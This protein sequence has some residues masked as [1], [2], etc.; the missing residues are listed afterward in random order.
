MNIPLFYPKVQYVD[1][2]EEEGWITLEEL[3]QNANVLCRASGPWTKRRIKMTAS[4]N[5]DLFIKAHGSRSDVWVQHPP[6]NGQ[7]AFRWVLGALAYSTLFDGVARESIKNEK[8]TT[9]GR[10]KGRPKSKMALS[11]K[12]R[13]RLFREKKNRA[14]EEIS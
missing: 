9:I 5:G 7:D 14:K 1:L 11:G 6:L 13:A 12:E 3:C 2:S 8:W 4:D 10:P